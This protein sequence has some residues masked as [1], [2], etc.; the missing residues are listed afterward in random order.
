MTDNEKDS[1][2]DKIIGNYIYNVANALYQILAIGFKDMW[3]FYSNEVAG[4]F[5][6]VFFY[7]VEEFYNNITTRFVG[8]G[9]IDQNDKKQLDKFLELPKPVRF[10]F[11]SVLVVAFPMFEIFQTIVSAFGTYRQK[12]NKKFSPNPP[13]A[14]GIL[15]AAF[16]VPSLTPQVREAMER[17]G[18]SKEDIDLMFYAQY[19]TYPIELIREIYFRDNKNPTWAQEKLMELGFPPNRINDIIKTFE[20]IPP[21]QDIMHLLAKEAFEPETIK[22]LGLDAEFPNEV[23]QWGQKHGLSAVWLEKYWIAHWQEIGLQTAFEMFQRDQMSRADLEYMFKTQ[24]IAPWYREKLLNI[25]YQPITRVDIRRMYEDG[26]I[27]REEMTRRYRHAGYA[28]DDAELMS[29]WTE[30]YTKRE[31]INRAKTEVIGAYKQRNITREDAFNKLTKAGYGIADAN[32]QLDLVDYRIE[33]AI[34]DDRINIV[35]NL[36]IDRIINEQEAIT[37]LNKFNLPSKQSEL[38]MEQWIAKRQT[39]AALPSKTDLHKFALKGYIK[40]DRYRYFFEKLGYDDEVTNYYWQL[41][42]DQQEIN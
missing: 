11:I 17:T 8:A 3:N 27:D 18:L 5:N 23:I 12:L 22:H 38:L 35:G 24:E 2:F 29:D 7:P 41:V 21:I 33:K 19:Q 16:R 32:N 26:V 34:L 36:F 42:K 13:D 30:R 28:P 1:W 31:L 25:A 40:E 39:R 4:I 6:R 14:F 37:R 20:V 10:I 9:Y 15:G